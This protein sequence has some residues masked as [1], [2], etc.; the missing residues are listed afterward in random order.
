MTMY[1]LGRLAEI[2]KAELIGDPDQTV[3]RAQPFESAQEGDVTFAANAGYLSRINESMATAI[4]VEKRVPVTA[5]NLLI[6]ANPKLAFARAVAAIYG[7]RYQV[8]GLSND[9]V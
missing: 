4:I 5:R 3:A 9:L 1:T 6:A 8:L 2:I 7:R